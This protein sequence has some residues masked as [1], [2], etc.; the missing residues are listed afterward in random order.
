MEDA[1]P[2]AR[3]LIAMYGP[4]GYRY[5]DVVHPPRPLPDVLEAIRSRVDTAT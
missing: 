1:E 4:A 2:R 5:S 3:R